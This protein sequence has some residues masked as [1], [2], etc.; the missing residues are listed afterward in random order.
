MAV[1]YHEVIAKSYGFGRMGCLRS[2]AQ[3]ESQLGG[4]T[5]SLPVQRRIADGVL[6]FTANV[7]QPFGDVCIMK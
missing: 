4:A 3:M 2:A 5:S 7:R 6:L 1:L